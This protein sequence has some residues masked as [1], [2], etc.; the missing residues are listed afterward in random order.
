MPSFF[1]GWYTAEMPLWHIVWQVGATVGF[2]V[3]GALGSWPGWVALG[4]NAAAWTGLVVQARVAG[5]ARLVFQAAEEEVP[6]AVPA[7]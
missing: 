6:F 7:P 5:G 4:V 2:V 1:A 3:A